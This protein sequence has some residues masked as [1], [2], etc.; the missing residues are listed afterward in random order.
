MGFISAP[1]IL[2]DAVSGSGSPRA[3]SELQES[4]T[5][6]GQCRFPQ[7]QLRAWHIVRAQSTFRE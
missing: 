2:G 6:S 4:G 3:D 1:A 5:M 7:A